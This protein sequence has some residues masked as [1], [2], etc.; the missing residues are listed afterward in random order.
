M[1]DSCPSE[2]Q[3]LSWEMFRFLNYTDLEVAVEQEDVKTFGSKER[4]S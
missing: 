4:V 2:H 1:L 3:Q